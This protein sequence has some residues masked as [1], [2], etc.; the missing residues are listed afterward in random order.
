M[1]LP[2][3]FAAIHTCWQCRPW[4]QPRWWHPIRWQ[5]QKFVTH[6]G[7]MDLTKCAS[8]ARWI[9]LASQRVHRT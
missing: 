3:R 1:A 2:L 7:C 4:A 6:Q 9:F 5:L 8:D